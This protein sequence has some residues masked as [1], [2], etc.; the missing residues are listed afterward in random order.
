MHRLI[1]DVK[2]LTSPQAAGRLA[3]TEGAYRTV[4]YLKAELDSLGFDSMRQPVD[5]P[6]AR[7]ISTPRLIVGTQA[8]SP[9]RDFAEL[10]ALSAGGRVKSQLRV[11]RVENLLAPN[12]RRDS[13]LL[14]RSR[15]PSNWASRHCL[16][17]TANR[18]G[19]VAAMTHPHSSR[20][21]SPRSGWGSSPQVRQE[22]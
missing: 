11:V 5:V 9:R 15:S 16:S 2:F 17:N 18:N 21:A 1:H 4:H 12:A 13:T 7:L 3:G 20:R 14:R 6:A 19:S 22:A 8:F 10:T